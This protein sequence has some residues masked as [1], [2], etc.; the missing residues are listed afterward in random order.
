[1]E[2]TSGHADLA[3]VSDGAA[4]TGAGAGRAAVA[5]PP[6]TRVGRLAWRLQLAVER[7]VARASVLPDKQVYPPEDFAWAPALTAD[8][9]AVRSEALE[10]LARRDQLPGFHEVLKEVETITADDSW[11]A[12]FLLGIGMDCRRNAERCPATMEV[13]ARIPGAANA[14]FSILAPG[15]H[16]PA[17]RGV[18]NGL[19]RLHLG[20]VV[21]EPAERCR[22]R[23]GADTHSWSEGGLLIFDDT[24]NHEVWNETDGWRVVLFVD[25]ARPLKQPW[26]RLNRALIGLGALAPF[27]READRKQ[28]AWAAHYDRAHPRIRLAPDAAGGLGSHRHD[29]VIPAVPTPKP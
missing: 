22:I 12:F 19:L 15:K 9:R 28:Q 11:K 29:G 2:R 6:R 16:I 20:L 27:L 24:F 13:V 26:H 1:M 21:P 7:A 25:F 8:W 4:E 17:H 10:V 3:L 14:F 18:Y 5:A 23:I